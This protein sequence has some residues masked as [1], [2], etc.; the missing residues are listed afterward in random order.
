[1]IGLTPFGVVSDVSGS[2]VGWGGWVVKDSWSWSVSW[3]G[4]LRVVELCD[5]G[6]KGG[7]SE[8]TVLNCT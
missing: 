7:F 5:A 2:I 4:H 8:A 1:M 6:G 3:G